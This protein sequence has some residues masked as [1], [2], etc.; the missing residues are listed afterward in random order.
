M[1]QHFKLEHEMKEQVSKK[2]DYLE[3][4]RK[5]RN[6]NTSSERGTYGIKSSSRSLDKAAINLHP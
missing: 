5:C 1:Q 2:R 4:K 6:N 3:R